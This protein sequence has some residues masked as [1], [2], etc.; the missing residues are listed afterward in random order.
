LWF[1]ALLNS[2]LY[3]D[4]VVRAINK[5]SGISY[6][7]AL[8]EFK[9]RQRKTRRSWNIRDIC[10]KFGNLFSSKRSKEKQE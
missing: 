9:E 4:E 8:E 5:H 1:G 3:Y 10:K 6:F 7:K 2:G